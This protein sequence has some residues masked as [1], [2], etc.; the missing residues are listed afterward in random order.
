M[1]DKQSCRYL[2]KSSSKC[3]G[4]IGSK[5]TYGSYKG[6]WEEQTLDLASVLGEGEIAFEP[7]KQPWIYGHPRTFKAHLLDH[8]SENDFKSS[9][10]TWLL[11]A[12]DRG[13]IYRMLELSGPERIAHIAD[14]IYKYQVSAEDS[15]LAKVPP[16]TRA[17]ML[18]HTISGMEP[19]EPLVHG[20]NVI[21]LCWKRIYLLTSQLI[22]LQRQTNLGKRR[23]HVHV[24]NN[25]QKEYRTVERAIH[26]FEDWQSKEMK[27]K[28]KLHESFTSPLKISF[29]HNDKAKHC[30]ARFVYVD[31]LRREQPLEEVVFLDDDQY[32]PPT[33]LSL[34][35][36]KHRTKSMTTW[37]GKTFKKNG[38]NNK[39]A[40]YWEPD[41]SFKDVVNGEVETDKFKYG[42]PGGSI[43]DANLWLFQTQLLRLDK[44]LS[45][46]AKIDDL[47]VSY[48]LDALLGW[49][50]NRLP[51][52][53]I[54]IDIGL[55]GEKKSYYDIMKERLDNET[56]NELLTITTDPKIP[57]IRSVATFSDPD[58]D[59][60]SM[61]EML[62]TKF[63]W[64]P[65]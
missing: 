29:V 32:F 44:D 24:L 61:F 51:H 33:L 12:S 11:K 30:F 8:I 9:D 56:V 57:K 4:W 53:I 59:K 65:T 13:F 18:E 46:W 42:G 35:V 3:N 63:R 10:G 64:D 38:A 49:D 45:L 6:R 58:V 21:L 1:P 62:Q 41:F 20:L 28:G 5:R 15:T 43:I 2:D 47:W 7:R 17:D 52:E 54:P 36:E 55:F 23:V 39:L 16:L 48:A 27:D 60:Q 37:Y 14:K 22:W 31:E 40:N 26:E 34:F 19:S 50:I 25:N